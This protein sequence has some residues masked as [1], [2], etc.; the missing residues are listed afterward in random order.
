[1][2]TY[3]SYYGLLSLI[4]NLELIFSVADHQTVGMYQLYVEIE[5]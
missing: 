5:T 4:T 1:M 2:Q 3:R